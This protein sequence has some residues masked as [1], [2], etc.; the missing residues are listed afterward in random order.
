MASSSKTALFLASIP[1][2]S[3]DGNVIFGGSNPG[4]KKLDEWT[5]QSSER[6]VD[7]SLA[8]F[9]S[10]TKEVRAFVESEFLDSKEE[11]QYAPGEG[12]LYAWSG[13]IGLSTDGVSF[14]GEVSGERGVWVCAG[15]HGQ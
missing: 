3:S 10:V 4:Q 5:A 2:C 9:E 11:V 7:E 15:H 8:N 12:W 14:V 1:R 13:I 6:C